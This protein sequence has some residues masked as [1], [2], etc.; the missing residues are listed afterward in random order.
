MG[1]DSLLTDAMDLDSSEE[2]KL[3]RYN[4]VRDHPYL[5]CTPA[6]STVVGNM[7][8]GNTVACSM[9]E[10][11]R[12]AREDDSKDADSKVLGSKVFHST[13]V[14]CIL[15]RNKVLDSTQGKAWDSKTS[16][17]IEAGTGVSGSRVVDCT[18]V[19]S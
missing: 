18:G 8:L 10:D 3:V 15:G 13:A 7:P 12:K 16:G 17:N 1:V 2:D 4:M 5:D 14:G 11:N 6:Y 9:E 19:R